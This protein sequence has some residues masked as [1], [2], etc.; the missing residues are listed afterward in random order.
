MRKGFSTIF[1]V[2]AGFF[3]YMISL[4]AFDNEHPTGQK[5]GMLLGLT[6]PALIAMTIGIAL[7]HFRNW[8]RDVGIVLLSAVGF[9]AFVI[10]TFACLLINGEF[11]KMIRPD[12]VTFFSD[13]LTGGVVI[14][15]LAI[16]GWMLTKTNKK[17]AEQGAILGGDSATLH[18]RQ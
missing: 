5:L 1:K 4:L 2:I 13:Y 9:T 7:S 18:P 11:R 15:G 8:R 6:A 14:V 3:F 16:L 17:V 10:F 12:T